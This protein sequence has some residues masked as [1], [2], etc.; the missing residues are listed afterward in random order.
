[1]DLITYTI[2]EAAKILKCEEEKILYAGSRG[3]LKIYV[4]PS[5]FNLFYV[6]HESPIIIESMDISYEIDVNVPWDEHNRLPFNQQMQLSPHCL[7]RHLDGETDMK[8]SLQ[9]QICN[10]TSLTYFG[11]YDLKKEPIKLQECELVVEA[12]DI[13]NMKEAI[14][15]KYLALLD[16]NEE[17]ENFSE[18]NSL[19]IEK[20]V[21]VYDERKIS[22]ENWLKR[23]GLTFNSRPKKEIFE[24]I[25]KANKDNPLWELNYDSYEKIFYRPYSKEIG[26]IGRSGAPPKSKRIK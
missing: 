18:N 4:L 8:L 7:R 6:K 16:P 23:S 22:L 5:N 3:Y 12:K 26:L 9:G 21:T 25:K 17:S 11:L 1:M 15:A 10:G 20:K 13:N 14:K 2:P 19:V 24:M